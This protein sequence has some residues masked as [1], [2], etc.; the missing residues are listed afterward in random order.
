MLPFSMYIQETTANKYTCPHK[1]E[2]CWGS[3]CM[4]WRWMPIY[5]GPPSTQCPATQPIK[6]ST[7][8]GY[9][10]LVK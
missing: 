2:T 6:F 5:A 10:G 9:C 7:E 1:K 8:L 3:R 4:A